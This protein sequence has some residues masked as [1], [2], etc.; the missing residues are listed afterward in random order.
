MIG[1]GGEKTKRGSKA[2]SARAPAPG[3][4]ERTK[5]ARAACLHTHNSSA[6]RRT[7]AISMQRAGVGAR[8]RVARGQHANRSSYHGTSLSTLCPHTHR[9][10]T[11]QDIARMPWAPP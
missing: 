11:R 7:A 6:E 10:R 3:L 5:S 4:T 2:S 1:G 8:A 9:T